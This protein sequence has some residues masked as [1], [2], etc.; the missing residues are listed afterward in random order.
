MLWDT[1]CLQ[2]HMAFGVYLDIDKFSD[3]ASDTAP[4]FQIL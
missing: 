2:E 3:V 1:N 4:L